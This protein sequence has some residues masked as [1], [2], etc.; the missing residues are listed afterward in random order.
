V[1]TNIKITYKH[2]KGLINAQDFQLH[3]LEEFEKLR[4]KQTKTKKGNTS[5]MAESKL[6]NSSHTTTLILKQPS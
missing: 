5:S 3:L 6:L 2:G 1:L 4:V